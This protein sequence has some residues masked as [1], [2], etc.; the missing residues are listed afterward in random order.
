M[1]EDSGAGI[2]V[3]VCDEGPGIPEARRT[4]IFERFYTT[5]VDAGGTGLGLAIVDSVARAHGGRI[6]FDTEVGAGSRFHFWLPA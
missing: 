5:D 4:K 6:T 2:R 1:C 3:S